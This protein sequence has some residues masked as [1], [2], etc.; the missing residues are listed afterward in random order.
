MSELQLGLLIFGGLAVVG[1]VVYNRYQERRVRRKAEQAFGSRHADVLLADDAPRREPSFGGAPPARDA[2]IGPGEEED[3]PDDRLDYVIELTAA[4]PLPTAVMIEGWKPLE[5][6]FGRRALLAWQEDDGRWRRPLPGAAGGRKHW[7]AAL[8]LVSRAGVVGEA[9]LVEFRSEIETLAA[10]TGAA[11][12]APEMR[13]ALERARALDRDCADADIQ[14]AIHVVGAPG[15]GFAPDDVRRALEAHAVAAESQ[16]RW[17][18]YDAEGRAQFSIVSEEA[19]DGACA[20]L[21]ITLD[22]PRT[23]ELR[24]SYETMVLVTRGLAATL[25]ASLQDDNGRVLDEHALRAIGTQLDAV[26]QDL[27]RQGFPPGGVRALRL[28]S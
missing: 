21:T 17:T 22:V 5:R 8:Q 9:E 16:G 7:R 23:P 27:E 12:S 14:V 28:F 3:L 11:A 19:P 25:G 18:R 10:R 6:R 1:V 24:R 20:R 26:R 4:S 13:E 2:P 15:A